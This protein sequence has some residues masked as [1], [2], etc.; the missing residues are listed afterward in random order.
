[1]DEQLPDFTNKSVVFY[2]TTPVGAPDW[3]S[4]GLVLESPSFQKHNNR[5]FVTGQTPQETENVGESDW[6]ANRE[7]AIAWDSV[8]YYVVLPSDEY[9]DA[10]TK[11][12]NDNLEVPAESNKEV[13]N[14][15]NSSQKYLFSFSLVIIGIF[16]PIALL[17]AIIVWIVKML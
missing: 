3:F 4:E 7:A 1:M 16:I 13:P 15:K 9:Q 10:R 17:V 5:I 8:F 11:D 14:A 6:S 2:I 12:A